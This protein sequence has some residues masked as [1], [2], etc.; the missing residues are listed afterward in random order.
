MYPRQEQAVADRRR[1]GVHE[2]QRLAASDAVPEAG[3]MKH[4]ED[5]LERF[6]ARAAADTDVLAVIVSGSL[7]RG[8]ERADSDI[9]L[10]VVVTEER[11][12][13]AFDRHRLM[14]VERE[15]A[16]YPGGYFDIKLATLSYLDDAAA[17][18]DDPV[19]DS[20]ARARIAY[21]R[22]PDLADS[23]AR[24]AVVPEEQWQKR[25]ASHLAQARLHGGYFL[26]QG[27]TH[28]DDLLTAHAA[29]HL[30]TAACR[31]LLARD[32]V[33]YAG[34]KYLRSAVAAL[35][36]KPDGFDAAIAALVHEPTTARGRAVLELLESAADWPLS[37]E[38]TLSTFVLE[39]ELAWR[40]RQS[41]PEYR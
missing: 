41:P 17:R 35:D 25:M 26:V 29:V 34:P 22:V 19:R 18:G 6:V 31:A 15:G 39:N 3:Q 20:F 12:A 7:S 24:I 30:A 8:T 40:Y 32:R 38:Q 5:A 4:H 1:V 16:D 14:Y 28:G 27:L 37:K 21:S 33:L 23:L 13:D 10:Y 11:W 9:D 36:N 2:H